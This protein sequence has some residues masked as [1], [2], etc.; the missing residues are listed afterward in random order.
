MSRERGP[1]LKSS[2]NIELCDP[3]PNLISMNSDEYT[4]P[5][6]QLDLT[7]IHDERHLSSFSVIHNC[8]R[9]RTRTREDLSFN[10]IRITD[11]V[12]ARN[13]LWFLQHLF[14]ERKC[15]SLA[16]CFP[17]PYTWMILSCFIQVALAMR[18]SPST[19]TRFGY[20]GILVRPSTRLD[21]VVNIEVV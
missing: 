15:C 7:N 10:I 2:P 18:F 9:T 17:V 6:H 5:R 16:R 1:S 14:D 12:V 8:S 19:I 4:Q 11:P 21:I 20:F 3:L 13:W